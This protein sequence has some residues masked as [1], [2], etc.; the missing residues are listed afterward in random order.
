MRRFR[1]QFL[2]HFDGIGNVQSD[3][4]AIGPDQSMHGGGHGLGNLQFGGGVGHQRRGHHPSRCAD[5][6]SG[7]K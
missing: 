5:S 7:D 4:S 1:Q 3:L 2:N 6:P